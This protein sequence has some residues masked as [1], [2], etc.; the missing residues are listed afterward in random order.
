MKVTY[1]KNGFYVRCIPS[2]Q[3]KPQTVFYCSNTWNQNTRVT[4]HHINCKA[5]LFNGYCL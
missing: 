4:S 5:L 2:G 1:T 3:T